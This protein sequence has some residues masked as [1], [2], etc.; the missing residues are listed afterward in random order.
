MVKVYQ[1]I[2][3]KNKESSDFEGQVLFVKHGKG[4][5]AK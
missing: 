4:I 2:K 3:E 1:R 5:G